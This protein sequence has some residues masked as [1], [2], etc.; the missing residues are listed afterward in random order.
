MSDGGGQETETTTTSEPWGGVKPYLKDLFK[1][2]QTQSE[3]G[4]SY[5]P[6]S[7]VAETS[8]YTDAYIQALADKGS[9]GSTLVDNASGYTSDVLAG[10]Y[11]TD[12]N[13]Y[14]DEMIGN[15]T[16]QIGGA[17]GDRFASSGGY[18]GSPSEVQAVTREVSNAALPYLFQDYTS[19][20][21][22]MG[23][24][25]KTAGVIDQLDTSNLGLLGQAGNLEQSNNQAVLDDLV[26]RW[27]YEQQAP[28]DVLSRYSQLI[29][30]GLNFGT[31]T[32][33]NSNTTPPDTMSQVGAGVQT[34]ASLAMMLAFI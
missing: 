7:T 8:P 27:N 11:L 6:N 1:R 16:D 12:Q 32:S 31:S 29:Q 26:N 33:L 20:R 19:E 34:A 15:F 25:A 18:M 14:M 3:T 30:P 13:P 2:A 5:Y 17:I 9:S 28:W 21:G 10:N 24:A 22:N 4:L 23:E